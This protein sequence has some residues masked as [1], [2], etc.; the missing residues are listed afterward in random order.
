MLIGVLLIIISAYWFFAPLDRTLIPGVI[1]DCGTALRP[2]TNPDVV[3][4]CAAVP[5]QALAT[6]M[7]VAG[8]GLVLVLGA[9]LVFGGAVRVDRES[10][11]EDAD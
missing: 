9:G 11:G 6:G 3:K 1:A 10:N 8:C 4:E 7:V 5:G 2:P